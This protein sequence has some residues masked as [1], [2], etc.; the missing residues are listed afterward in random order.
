MAEQYSL[1]VLKSGWYPVMKRGFKDPVSLTWCE[2]G[3][4]W[5]FGKTINPR[6]RYSVTS[7]KNIG[8]H[9]VEYIKEFSSPQASQALT[10]EEMKIVNYLFQLGALPPG[11]KVKR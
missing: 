7:L 6:T 11:N 5:K 3:D 10:V 2:K 9:G 8:E 4:V 1:R